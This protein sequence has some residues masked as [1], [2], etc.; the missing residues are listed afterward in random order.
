M[1]TS[2]FL[3]GALLSAQLSAHGAPGAEEKTGETETVVLSVS[4]M[5]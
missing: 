5:T 2:A 1:K 4:G 3:L